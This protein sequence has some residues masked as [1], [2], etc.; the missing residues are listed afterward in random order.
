VGAATE[1]WCD[2]AS[3]DYRRLFL[4][5]LSSEF[6]VDSSAVGGDL[7]VDHV[8]NRAFARKHGLTF[9]RMALLPGVDNTAYGRLLEK[10]FT[11]LQA[12]SKSMYLMDASILMKLLGIQPPENEAAYKSRRRDIATAFVNAGYAGPVEG[13]LRELDGLF[14][15]WKVL[16]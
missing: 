15:L 2:V 7:H 10:Q 4:A 5:F 13:A 3:E 8:L 16:R 14:K 11:G 1:Y 6:G 12:N 9:V